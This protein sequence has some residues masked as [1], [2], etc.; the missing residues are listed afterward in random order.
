MQYNIRSP[1]KRISL[2]SLISI[3]ALVGVSSGCG[4][5]YLDDGLQ[6]RKRYTAEQ[7]REELG[8]SPSEIVGGNRTNLFS[9]QQP[10]SP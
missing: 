4:R 5:F 7:V 2:I 8:I 10:P 3:I 9:R 1:I 6:I